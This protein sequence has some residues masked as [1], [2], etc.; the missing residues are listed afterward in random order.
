MTFHSTVGSGVRHYARHEYRGILLAACIL[1]KASEA[2]T[3]DQPL[4]VYLS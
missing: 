1:V 2:V 4:Q 3:T